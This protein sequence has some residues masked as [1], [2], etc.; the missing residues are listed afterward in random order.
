MIYSN[1]ETLN[2]LIELLTN[3]TSFCYVRYGD[4]DFISMYPESVGKVIGFHNK[5]KVTREIQQ[6][7]IDTYL[8]DAPNFLIGT[9]DT[10]IHKRSMY[11][12]IDFNKVSTVVKVHPTDLY[13]AIALQEGF[14]ENRELFLTFIKLIN[15]KKTLFLNHYYEPVLDLF[16]GKIIT[17]IETPKYN[18]I[19]SYNY[20]YEKI[21]SVDPNSY[22]QII[23][24]CGQ[25]SRAIAKD[26]FYTLKNKTIIDIGS[27][28]DKL[29][30]SSKSFSNISVRSHISK[31]SDL[32]KLNLDY[33]ISILKI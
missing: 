21:L 8:T 23:L 19:E 26:L 6:K 32:V 17:H 22:D 5:T 24:S 4:G 14:L 2:R 18:A 10:I 7:L 31:N 33:Y 29:I 15:N 25:L 30:Y 13:S 1:K 12:N 16:L 11:K 20:F 27:L 28:S 3:K 9:L